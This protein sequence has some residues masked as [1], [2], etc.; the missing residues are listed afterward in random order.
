[1]R[2]RKKKMEFSKKILVVAGVLNIFVILFSCVMM[3]RTND[4]TPL[5]YLIPSI[6]A[7]TA[8]GT[9]F[10]YSKAKVE[11]RIMGTDKILSTSG[12]ALSIGSVYSDCIDSISLA[13]IDSISFKAGYV[14]TNSLSV[15]FLPNEIIPQGTVW[16]LGT[17]VYKFDKG[18]ID[19]IYTSTLYFGST[20][21][22]PSDYAKSDHTHSGYA[23]STHTHSDYASSSHTHSGYAASS[24]V[25]AT[26]NY[27][28]SI[29][30]TLNSSKQLVPTSSSGY[31]LGSSTYPWQ[32]AYI[33]NLYINDTKFDPSSTSGGSFAGSQVTMGGST[34][35]Y[36]VC[37]TSRELRPSH[38]STSYPCYLGTSTYPWHYAYIGSVSVMIGTSSSSYGGSKVGFYGT[39][40]IARK[41]ITTVSTSATSSTIAT[42]L[43][44]L[45]GYLKNYGLL[46]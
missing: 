11:N 30:V 4:L 5:T 3:W 39:T 14:A 8:T 7:E 40:P 37:N 27:S 2:Y 9:G 28:S 24:H 19:K 35:Y 17:S 16:S 1:M 32:Y 12:S 43:N 25:H 10:Y 15:N 29:Y 33:T 36:I 46:G 31:Y 44:E 26:I 20:Q 21:F 6:A 18:Y 41:S 13:A 45:I 42:K 34:S 22:K 23:S 38:T